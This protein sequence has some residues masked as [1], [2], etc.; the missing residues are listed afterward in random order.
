MVSG[1]FNV[2]SITENDRCLPVMYYNIILGSWN[3]L[4]A[5]PFTT[6]ENP[7][8]EWGIHNLK[9]RI[10]IKSLLKG[11]HPLLN[12]SYISFQCSVC[13]CVSTYKRKY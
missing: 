7:L 13:A 4:S 11:G 6:F 10:L 5:L 9:A 2:R 3:I 12:C 1:H 8:L